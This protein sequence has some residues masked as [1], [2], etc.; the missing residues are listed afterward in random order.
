MRVDI[1][2]VLV[3]YDCASDIDR[4]AVSLFMPVPAPGE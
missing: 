3:H 1:G 4:R 2:R